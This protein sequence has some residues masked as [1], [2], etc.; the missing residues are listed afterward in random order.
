MAATT[1]HSIIHMGPCGKMNKKQAFGWS[2][3]NVGI[4]YVN[5]KSEMDK[6]IY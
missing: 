4:F 1:G 2:L 6:V 3:T 5:Q